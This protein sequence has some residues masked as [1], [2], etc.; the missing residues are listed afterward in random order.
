MKLFQFTDMVELDCV[1][2]VVE[3]RVLMLPL[4]ET[5]WPPVGAA[6][7]AAADTDNAATTSLLRAEPLL[8]P[9]A[10]S[11]TAIQL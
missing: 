2:V 10:T 4:P 6:C 5:T 7:A 8:R 11:D 3:P 1:I 9:R